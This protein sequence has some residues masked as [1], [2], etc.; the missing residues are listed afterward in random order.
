MECR[1]MKLSRAGRPLGERGMGRRDAQPSKPTRVRA[2]PQRPS[3]GK[4]SGGGF[5]DDADR[6]GARP[7]RETGVVSERRFRPKRRPNAQG[8]RG[9]MPIKTER[10]DAAYRS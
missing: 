2:G 5:C 8:N 1:R 3:V 7:S 10:H 9:R 4:A 6:T